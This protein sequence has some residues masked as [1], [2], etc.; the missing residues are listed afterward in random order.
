M[1]HG[2]VVA[3]ME[4][5]PVPEQGV[6][7]R[8]GVVACEGALEHEGIG[9]PAGERGTRVD[10]ACRSAGGVGGIGAAEPVERLG[11]VVVHERLRVAGCGYRMPQRRVCGQ[12]EHAQALV[13]ESELGVLAR[14]VEQ[15]VGLG[16]DR[17]FAEQVAG[18]E[19][20]GVERGGASQ[21]PLGLVI[22]TEPAQRDRG[23]RDGLQLLGLEPQHL[24]GVREGGGP[25]PGRGIQPC[26]REPGRHAPCGVPQALRDGVVG[27]VAVAARHEHE[28]EQVV[29][30]AGGGVRV[31]ACLA[32]DR[33]AQ[34][35]LGVVEAAGAQ[36]ALAE[37]DVAAGVERVAAQ[38]LLPVRL[39][40][41]GRVPVLGEVQSGEV[42]L[43]RR[44]DGLRRGQLGR[45]LDGVRARTLGRGAAQQFGTGIRDHELDRPGCRELDPRA[46]RR[47][48]R[49]S[50]RRLPHHGADRVAQLGVQGGPLASRGDADAPMH[51]MRGAMAAGASTLG[52]SAS[53]TGS[54]VSR[55]ATSVLACC[56]GPIS[57]NGYQYWL[58]VLVSP[59]A[60][61]EKSGWLSV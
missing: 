26:H 22:A 8:V 51:A 21:H 34:V 13:L 15:V 46:Q 57:W 54:T 18:P 42:E 12:V 36:A 45:R 6:R 20:E 30:V 38:Q 27:A 19:V 2:V 10:V 9:Q 17:G 37:R 59:G 56:T 40:R 35:P 14:E 24:L 43:V 41:A 5:L 25:A 55:T 1:P 48:R 47:T 11:A 31:A 50:R 49:D 58:K 53:P 16:V 33:R 7:P 23:D 52:A 28:A 32:G 4:V 44:G 61:N 3:P 39:G 29:G 60:R